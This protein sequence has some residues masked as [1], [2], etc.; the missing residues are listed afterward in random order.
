M[1]DSTEHPRYWVITA[2]ERAFGPWD[3]WA[4]AYEFGCINLG[5]DGWTIT[6]T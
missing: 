2:D 1:T 6:T 5:F 4:C 3:D